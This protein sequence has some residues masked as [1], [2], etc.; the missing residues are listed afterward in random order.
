MVEG[1]NQLKHKLM[2]RLP[3]RVQQA[4]RDAMEKSADDVVSMMKRLAPIDSGDLQMSISWTWGDPP[5]GA[6]VVAQSEPGP[7]DLRITIFAGNKEA[8]YARWIEF[9]TAEM[10]AQPFFYPSWR[11]KRRSVRAR[12]ARA[13]KKAV[14]SEG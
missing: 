9:G 3:K 5:K 1:I 7:G 4:L 8:Y 13:M 11:T 2:V 14:E 6:V 12:M 10:R